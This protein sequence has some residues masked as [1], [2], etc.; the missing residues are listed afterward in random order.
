[1]NY[2][3]ILKTRNNRL[4]RIYVTNNSENIIIPPNSINMFYGCTSLVGG[5]GTAYDP[6][7]IDATAARIDGGSSNPG[8]F[9]DIKDKSVEQIV[10]NTK[11]VIDIEGKQYTV[12][13]QVEGN[14][15]K[16]LANELANYGLKMKFGSD[17]NYATSTIATYLDGEY[18]DRLNESVKSAVVETSIQQ[19]VSSTGYDSGKQSPTWTGETNEAGTHKVFIPSWDELAKAAGGTDVA[20]LMTFLNSKYVWLR[21][22]YGRLVLRVYSAGQ[23]DANNP[24]NDSYARPAMV[25]DLSKVN[26][27]KVEPG[28]SDEVTD[29][30]DA[31]A[32]VMAENTE[33]KV[34]VETNNN[35]VVEEPTTSEPVINE[36]TET[37][38]ESDVANEPNTEEETE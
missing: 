10:L 13:E 34:I 3:K 16:V 6:T 36:I 8:Y 38:N 27:T 20:T 29:D 23:L 32:P 11:D 12:I 21:D 18:Y 19:K 33:T 9:T 15:Y 31:I 14:Q 1:M 37:T 30:I 17:N 22:T 2:L 5:A 4:E 7:F 24:G 25:L 35:A 28:S 26:F